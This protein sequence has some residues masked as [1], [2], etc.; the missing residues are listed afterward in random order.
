MNRRKSLS[1]ELTTILPGMTIGA[2][3]W[4][5]YAMMKGTP[6]YRTWGGSH[7]FHEDRV[8]VISRSSRNRTLLQLPAVFA[9]STSVADMVVHGN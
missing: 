4:I 1:L 3:R 8:L 6:L 5:A 2:T 9:P 7:L